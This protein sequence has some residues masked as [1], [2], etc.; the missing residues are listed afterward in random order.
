MAWCLINHWDKYTL[1]HFLIF[2]FSKNPSG[3]ADAWQPP[4]HQRACFWPVFEA[5]TSR[6]RIMNVSLSIAKSGFMISF[7]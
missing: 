1:F 2:N 7:V 4:R 3:E 6:L 5:R